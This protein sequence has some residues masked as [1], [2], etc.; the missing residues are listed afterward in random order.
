MTV[1]EMVLGGLRYGKARLQTKNHVL[2]ILE[3]IA[4]AREHFIT[5]MK[6]LLITHERSR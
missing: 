2:I 3:M 5:R 4:S 6:A 1:L